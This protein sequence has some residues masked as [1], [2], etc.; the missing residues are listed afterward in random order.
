LVFF[1]A[2]V[3]QARDSVKLQG[4]LF[5]V[6]FYVFILICSQCPVIAGPVYQFE[7]SVYAFYCIGE[8]G[9][10]GVVGDSFYQAVLYGLEYGVEEFCNEVIG[11]VGD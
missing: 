8:A 2:E 3:F 10:A 7:F 5:G 9:I 1:V 11:V 4:V 6:V